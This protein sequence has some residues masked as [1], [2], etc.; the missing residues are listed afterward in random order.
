[1]LLRVGRLPKATV[2]PS[3]LDSAFNMAIPEGLR[4]ESSRTAFDAP[5]EAGRPDPLPGLPSPLRPEVVN[6]RDL[7][8][9]LEREIFHDEPAQDHPTP[10]IHETEPAD[11]V[12]PAAEVEPEVDSASWREVPVDSHRDPD[13][14]EAGDADTVDEPVPA[15]EPTDW[16]RLLEQI[17]AAPEPIAPP[18]AAVEPTQLEEVPV[19]GAAGPAFNEPPAETSNVIYDQE[20]ALT[21]EA[22][23]DAEAPTPVR[24]KSDRAMRLAVGLG[25]A[26]C[27]LLAAVLYEGGYF[28]KTRNLSSATA[29][30]RVSPKPST[31]HVV[32]SPSLAP[33]VSQPPATVLYTL[34]NG[35]AGDTVFRIR[36]GTAV[37]GYTRLVFDIHGNG[38]PGMV[39]TRPDSGHIEV[40]FKNTTMGNVPVN[41]IRSF[42]V[43]AVEP[44]VQAGSDASF[45]IDLARPVRVTA[46][47]LPATG[48]Y[49]WR[50]VVDLHT[51]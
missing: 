40:I 23:P 12:E 5:S 11:P 18:A 3:A 33:T 44:G 15:S 29:T 25:A 48:S 2:V 19:P 42:Q 26:A 50:L 36:P 35:V 43:S 32:S 20:P 9:E 51:S 46:F 4:L 49:A 41:G 6:A 28:L 45:I 34:G 8:S 1:M 39:I 10:L 14:H 16:S 31:S 17:A 37:A 27:V 21:F 24:P 30:T 38:L 13:L 7:M 22:E 47:T